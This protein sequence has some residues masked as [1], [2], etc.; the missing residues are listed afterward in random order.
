MNPYSMILNDLGLTSISQGD[1]SYLYLITKALEAGYSSG[2]TA[3]RTA[4]RF[5]VETLE[6]LHGA[7]CNAV[8]KIRAMFAT[9]GKLQ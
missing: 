8:R 6:A 7:D 1:N 2:Y 3:D 4:H 9:W 5:M